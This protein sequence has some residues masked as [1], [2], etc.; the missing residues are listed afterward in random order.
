MAKMTKSQ[1]MATLAEES[2][3]AKKDV[4]MLLEKMTN[5]AY[6]HV[7]SDGEFTLPGIGKLVKKHRA[8]RAGRNPATGATIQIPAKTVVKFRVAKAAKEAIL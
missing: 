7:K 5:M 8:A 2:G 4:V 3:L 6:K 1:M